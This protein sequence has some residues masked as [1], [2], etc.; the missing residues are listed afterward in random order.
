MP[1]P[2]PRRYLRYFAS[3]LAL[4]S[5]LIG[6]ISM[7][8][9]AVSSAALGGAAPALGGLAPSVVRTLAPFVT[10]SS[11]LVALVVWAQ[12]RAPDELALP[13]RRELVQALLLVLPGY[14]CSVVVVAAT[15]ASLGAVA[16]GVP[17]SLQGAEPEALRATD[18]LLGAISTLIDFGVL[19]L[20]AARFLA[21]LRA[22]G[23][24]LPAQL[25]LAWA[26]T[27]VLRSVT[28]LLLSS[29]LPG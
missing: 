12:W 22:S 1:S 13:L 8:Q 21:R 10:G 6:A 15:A 19:W 17:W 20:L 2:E 24:S 5:V 3:S 14:L 28:G 7:V 16:F 18:F 23:Y 26:V 27:A 9:F 4:F 11:A 25:A 29:V